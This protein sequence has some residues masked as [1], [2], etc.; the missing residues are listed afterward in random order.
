MLNLLTLKNIKCFESQD[1]K[2][3]PL[4]VL[5]GAN[6]A[7][8]STIIQA[9][10]LL[11]QS[12][13]DD[14]FAS[15]EIA[16]M[17]AYFSAGHLSDLI[18]HNARESTLL[19]KIDGVSFNID[20]SKQDK[21][22]YRMRF[23]APEAAVHDIF[24]GD[25][26]YLCAERLGPRN[27][28][29]VRFDSSRLNFG[30]YGEYAMAEFVR[31]AS[32]S[33][34]NQDLAQFY[35]ERTRADDKDDKDDITLEVA[36]K[37]VMRRIAPGFDI[38]YESHKTVDKVSN[39]FSSSTTKTAVRPV[40]TGFGVSYIF[41]IVVAAFCLSEGSTFIVENPEV[42]L[43]PSAQSELAQF[44]AKLSKTGVQVI[45]ETHSDHIINGIRLYA[46]A[47]PENSHDIVI[48]SISRRDSGNPVKF[49]TLDHDGNLSDAHPGFFDQAENDLLRLF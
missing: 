19:I 24:L 12:Y 31:R 8:K 13:N 46:K 5:C 15:S 29:D 43:H 6:S 35:S 44:L 1:F 48:N 7:G 17:G 45:I 16:L 49:I 37:T 34:I 10:L 11:R 36:V 21:E 9:L 22:S 27:S 30:I 33:A 2:F 25:F 14:R 40:N 38:N 18:S 26:V 39:V 41:P 20:P 32:R 4:T 47:N 23:S 3:S 28:Y 42:H